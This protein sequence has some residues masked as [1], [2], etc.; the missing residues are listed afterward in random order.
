MVDTNKLAHEEID[1]AITFI[2]AAEKAV[3]KDYVTVT[4]FECPICH[5][6]AK[7]VLSNNVLHAN[8]P[9]CEIS[10]IQ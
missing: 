6:P 5:E 2:Q 8:C 9:K 7:A 4:T 10:V 1:Q 3:E